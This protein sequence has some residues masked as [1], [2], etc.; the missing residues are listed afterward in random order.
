MIR[1]ITGLLLIPAAS[2]PGWTVCLDPGH[3]GSD[4]GATGIFYTEKEANLDVAWEAV[5]YLSMVPDCEWVGMTRTG[6]YNVSLAN[7][8]AYANQNGFDRFMSIHENA[9]NT[10]VQG[11]ETFCF[12]LD[13]GTPGYDMASKTLDGI[14]WAHGYNNRG[15]K[16]G[17][18]MYVIANTNMPA[19]LGEGSFIDYDGQ[20]NESHRYYTNWNDHS[21]RQGYAYARGISLHMGS[22]P[23][24]YGSDDYIVDN[25]SPGFSVNSEAEWN[26]GSYGEPWGPDYR[27]SSTTNQAD[28][29]RWTPN[30]GEAGWYE[31]YIWYT[32]G[33]NRAPD[34]LY[35]VFHQ[36]GETQFIVDQTQNGGQWILLGGFPF[37]SGSSGRV[38]LSEEGTTPERVVIADAVRFQM[39]GTGGAEE[40]FLPIPPGPVLSVSP[41]PGREFRIHLSTGSTAPVDL[42]VYDLSGRLVET[43][44]LRERHIVWNP[45]GL[46][47]GV[48]IVRAY[49]PDVSLHRKVVLLD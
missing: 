33:S 5:A 42:T 49:S 7:R 40:S 47:A 44:D 48:Y 46:P 37:E 30:L 9:F 22:E 13:P 32:H 11:S 41:N 16:D 39:S 1:W 28:W 8:V 12:S 24:V 4:P 23:P 19:M 20:W 21:G 26:T 3:G 17:S 29:A 31:V 6:D 43:L 27:W 18:W 36:S 35:T 10:N 38:E 2:L 14:L 15:V 34:A 45:S 25:L